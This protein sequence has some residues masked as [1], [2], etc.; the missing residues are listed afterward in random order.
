[1][2]TYDVIIIG[3]GA[4]GLMCANYLS[5]FSHG[6][7]LII[8]NNKRLGK[9][10][11]VTGNGRCN[12]SNQKIQE[13]AYYSY[14]KKKLNELY[15]EWNRY[16]LLK[17]FEELGL[18]TRTINN[19]IYPVSEQ[20]ISVVDV[21]EENV[22][23][24][25]QIDVLLETEVIDYKKNGDYLVTTSNNES[26]YGKTLIIAT[27][28]KTFLPIL[29]KHGYEITELSPALVKL[30]S[31][32][33]LLKYLHNTRIKGRVKLLQNKSL[34][35][36]EEGEIQFK[37]DALS[38][39]C[40]FN[41]SNLY[42]P[43]INNIVEIDFT[44][45]IEKEDLFKELKERIEKYPNHKINTLLN[46]LASPQLINGLLAILKIDKEQERKT[47]K[48]NELK[49]LIDYVKEYQFEI[50]KTG[51]FN[52]AQVCRG[53]IALSQI[54]PD[55][56][57]RLEDNVFIIGEILDIHGDCGGFNLD[58]CFKSGMLVAE[59][60]SKDDSFKKY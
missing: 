44:P 3:A 45:F 26:Y 57:S 30:M 32:D 31:S 22:R 15:N 2:K 55:F 21:L 17:Y 20:A 41:L 48:E 1:M 34:I 27:G 54:N 52:E 53:G 6:N 8:D 60:I 19:G 25:N 5:S 39:I 24:N 12:L 43:D 11:L 14:D 28:G 10:L 4:A 33:P 40:I 7:I 9:K 38:G 37:K 56:S 23:V 13:K 42:E 29:K 51:S 50:I 49:D 46:G 58:Y 35:K 18:Y 36:M 47:L 16:D 59:R